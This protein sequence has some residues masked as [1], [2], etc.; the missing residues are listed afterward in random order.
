[1]KKFWAMEPT[2]LTAYRKFK[3]QITTINSAPLETYLKKLQEFSSG[4]LTIID[5]IAVIPIRG[6]LSNRE[7][8]F[9]FIYDGHLNTY[10]SIIKM[11]QSAEANPEV[12]QIQLRVDSP[13]GRLD[14]LFNLLDVIKS[15]LKPIEAL[16]EN[17]ADSA[18]Y[19]IVSQA[20]RII[21]LSEISEVGSI[22]IGTSFFVDKEIIDITSSD[23]PKKWP[24]VTTAEGVNVVKTE[25]DEIHIKF[26]G[27]IAEGRSAA[28][29]KKVIS[30]TVNSNFGQGGTMLAEAA[31][32]AG[33]IDEI[34]PPPERT[35]NASFFQNSE[36][37]S[38]G[39][40][41]RHTQAEN[42]IMELTLK[43]LKDDYPEVHQAAI[44]SEQD[45]VAALL[46]TGKSCGRMDYAIKCVENGSR[47]TDDL[48]QA[49]F[50]SARINKKDQEKRAD[51]DPAPV[52]PP[53]AGDK[54]LDEVALTK[55][56]LERRKKRGLKYGKS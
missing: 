2:A 33:M 43:S 11:I 45:R 37:A 29:G 5:G 39:L 15:A 12:K 18:A 55:K 20:D 3:A 22:G 51:D 49:E 27:I 31:L 7:S 53:D 13:G 21:A 8:F 40:H 23:A 46:K 9:S 42:N 47:I 1:M 54:K 14:G 38:S 4:D 34:I 17:R 56:Y 28:T 24:D 48:V 36:P 35:S 26:A 16:I 32:S 52:D 50:L 41:S 44:K 19:G 25:L 30:D 10:P 6:I